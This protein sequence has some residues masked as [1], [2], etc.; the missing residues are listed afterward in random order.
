MTEHSVAHGTFHI[1]RTFAA[2]RGRVFAAWASHS[3]K[4]AWFGE[5]DDFLNP[6]PEYTLDFRVGGCERLEG[7]LPGGNAFLYEAQYQ[8]I[9]EDA[10]IIASYEVAING[11]RTSVSLLTVEFE[12]S[13]TGTRL[14]MTEQGAFLD[15]L[16]SNEQRQEGARESLEQLAGFLAGWRPRDVKA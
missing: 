9:I 8:D 5:G 10:R 6:T 2:P 11:R 15:G 13:P 12:E 7:T 1:E 14:L 3:A 4:N 16:D